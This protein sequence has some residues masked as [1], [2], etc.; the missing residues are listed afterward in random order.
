MDASFACAI[1]GKFPGQSYL[2]EVGI[3]V[4]A[5]DY[6][7]R[8]HPT[9]CEDSPKPGVVMFRQ[10]VLENLGGVDLGI[11]RG[12]S[13]GVP[14]SEHNEGRAWDWGVSAG[15]PDDV[16]RVEQLMRWLLDPSPEGEPHANFRRVGLRYMVWNRQIWSGG[17]KEWRAYTGSDPHTN[18][19][20]F[21]WDWPG[22]RAETSFYDWLREGTRPPPARPRMQGML[23]PTLII[24]GGA[25]AGWWVASAF[26]SGK[27]K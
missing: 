25:V 27:R 9:T 10:F 12:C 21:S 3:Q 13:G 22:A 14:R 11:C 20:H 5:E 23:I 15:S 6:A 1:I 18:H 19:V 24:G 2:P 17:T 7:S 8:V 16:R 26:L 4:S